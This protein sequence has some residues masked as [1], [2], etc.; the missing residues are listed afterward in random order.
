MGERGP[1]E[2][3]IKS[4]ATRAGVPVGSL[5]QYFPDR[6]AM[7]IA[8]SALAATSLV[9]EFE[10]AAEAASVLSLE[11]GIESLILGVH[12]W[13]DANP[14]LL[15]IFLLAI[16]RDGDR[17][18]SAWSR[19]FVEPVVDASLGIVRMIVA[20]G[21]ARGEVDPELSPEHA[22][23]LIHPIIAA[24]C[25]SRLMPGLDAYYRLYEG[26][27][28]SRSVAREAAQFAARALAPRTPVGGSLAPGS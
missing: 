2:A 13:S 12:S 4:V 10:A 26:E 8:A 21:A 17:P 27:R 11:E 22:A 14:S 23:R 28:D 5:Y 18:P 24:V 7:I 6:D 20:A 1:A 3:S 25:D 16:Y 9:A 15:R 19:R